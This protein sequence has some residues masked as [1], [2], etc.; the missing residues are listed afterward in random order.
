MDQKGMMSDNKNIDFASVKNKDIFKD[1]DGNTYI[2]IKKP[3]T[4]ET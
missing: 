2:G 4:M 1:S 3:Q